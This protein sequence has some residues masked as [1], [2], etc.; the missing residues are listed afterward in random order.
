[1]KRAAGWAVGCLA[2]VAAGAALAASPQ[3]PRISGV[4]TLIDQG[5]SRDPG[6]IW[7][8]SFD[9]PASLLSRY[10]EYN[11]NGGDFVPVTTEALGGTGQSMRVRWQPGEVGAGGLSFVF[12][13]NPM[14]YRGVAVRPT[15]DFREIYWRMYLKNQPGWTGNPAKLSRAISFAGSNWS[16]AM[17]GHVWGG[18]GSD[19]VIDPARGVNSSSQVVTTKYNDFANL[20]WLGYR[21][22]PYPIFDTAESGRWVEV[23]GH[24]RMNS[25]GKSDGVFSL[26]IDGQLQVER[27]DLNWVYSWHAYGINAVFLENYWNSG[28]PVTQERYF[29]DFVVST[30]YIG[31]AKSPLNPWVSKTG[32][33]D[34][35]AGDAQAAWQLELAWNPDGSSI[36]WDSGVVAGASAKIAVNDANGDFLG[37]LGGKHE[38]AQDHLYALRAR[39]RDLAGNWSAWS[40]WETALRTG[41]LTPGDA[42]G[43]GKI[44]GGDLS[45]W[46]QNYDPLGFDNDTFAMGDWN[47]DGNIDGGDLALWQRNYAPMG[48][49]SLG[50]ETALDA[51]VAGVPEPGT[52]LL[53]GAGG[54][55]AACARSRFIG[56]L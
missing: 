28:S 49:K 42:N 41:R 56:K 43:D 27:T 10:L 18:N 25:P 46:Q 20:T 16:E 53:L 35:D 21:S 30:S 1:M 45:A 34:P 29:D 9:G 36:V 3:S 17:I 23:E 4:E 50:G 5:W 44:D 55:V 13:R 40:P 48:I 12:G 37:L 26:T 19:L 8:D 33:L 39:Q 14:D 54:L 22:A 32:F 2:V 47:G 7:Y 15:E 24:V 52:L 11:N 31:M 38:L 6:V 51:G